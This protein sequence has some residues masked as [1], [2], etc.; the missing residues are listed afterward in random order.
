MKTKQQLT[1]T[2]FEYIQLSLIH[3]GIAKWT[4]SAIRLKRAIEYVLS[5]DTIPE[6]TV[7]CMYRALAE[8]EGYTYEVMEHSLRYAIN[9]LWSCDPRNCSKLFFRSAEPLQCPSVS[10]FLYLYTAAF[11]RGVIK[12]YVDSLQEQNEVLDEQDR[13][14]VQDLL[15]NMAKIEI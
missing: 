4:K 10:H 12:E 3:L 2:D 9:N 11:Q 14:G 6:V 5:H 8:Q 13:K 15:D 7:G 1:E